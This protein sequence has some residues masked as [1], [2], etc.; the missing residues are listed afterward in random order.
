MSPSR[1]TAV[2][3]YQRRAFVGLLHV[4]VI[5][6]LP[7]M[8]LLAP[9]TVVAQ[10][11]EPGVTA[12]V[13]PREIFEGQ[14]VLYTVFVRNIGD[15]EPQLNGFDDFAVEFRGDRSRNETISLRQGNRQPTVIRRLGHEYQYQ[16]TPLKTGRLKIPPA[17]VQ[18]EGQQYKSAPL[19]INVTA[20]EDQ[21]VIRLEVTTDRSSV[22]RAQSFTVS[23]T[24][25]VKSLPRSFAT[26]NPLSLAALDRGRSLFSRGRMRPPH[27]NVPWLDDEQLRPGLEPEK[28]WQSI[29][30]PIG[31][32]QGIGF[33]MNDVPGTR[34]FLDVIDRTF[35]PP[36]KRVQLEDAQ[37]AMTT[38]WQFV[39]SRR[40]VGNQVGRHTLEPCIVQGGFGTETNGSSLVVEQVFAKSNAATVEVLD[41]PTEGRPAN[42]IGVSGKIDDFAGNLSPKTARVGDPLTLTV[43]LR[44]SGTLDEATA[45]NLAAIPSLA[46]NFRLLDPTTEMI[47][48]E[49]VFTYSLRPL[50]T[51]VKEIPRIEASYFDVDAEQF[52]PISTS[53]I[54]L[55]VGPSQQLSANQIVAATED[56]PADESIELSDGGLFGNK[57]NVEAFRQDAI[58][59]IRW[60][61]GWGGLLSSYAFGWLI[62]GRWQSNRADPARI[63]RRQAVRAAEECLSRAQACV[64]SQDIN[65]A[66]RA[67]REMFVGLIS[68][69]TGQPAAGM[70]PREVSSKLAEL[71][72]PGDL[73]AEVH[74]LLERCDA[75]RYGLAT[76]IDGE[77]GEAKRVLASLASEFHQRGLLS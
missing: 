15:V 61:V 44:G 41:I 62:M 59:P 37:G 6:P 72:I 8:S 58:R 29:L 42:Y 48:G 26:R 49:R 23:L 16:L 18:F 69:V 12:E 54:P 35:M 57:T 46:D 17:V 34:S 60:F 21:D 7:F 25:D 43:R 53:S 74:D 52:L 39:F 77:V 11:V 27:L 38:Y 73:V 13:N 51:D 40:V 1:R 2:F 31:N 45:P 14:S 20:A 24:V 9:D 65:A 75:G 47:N 4:F 70:T 28:D 22:Y 55:H 64:N 63:R 68:D 33:R 71:E 36:P 10:D 66:N 67:V 3:S 56:T 76:S 5:A 30:V 50:T 32:E 19:T